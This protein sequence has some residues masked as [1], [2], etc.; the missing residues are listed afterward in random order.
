MKPKEAREGKQLPFTYNSFSSPALQ[1]LG[2]IILYPALQ[3]Y[4]LI[5]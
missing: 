4:R 2:L 5:T 1:N 3:N